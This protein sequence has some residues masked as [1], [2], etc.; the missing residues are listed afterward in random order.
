MD[1]FIGRNPGVPQRASEPRSGSATVAPPVGSPYMHIG[2]PL[3]DQT[4]TQVPAEEVGQTAGFALDRL[5]GSRS[6]IEPGHSELVTP[7][8]PRP[9][10]HSAGDHR[11]GL[12]GH[13]VSSGQRSDVGILGARTDHP[14]IV[15][16]K[17]PHRLRRQRRLKGV[18]VPTHDMRCSAFDV[19]RDQPVAELG[20]PCFE[21]START[22][23]VTEPV[24]KVIERRGP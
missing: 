14:L 5:V 21:P 4:Q 22:Q 23:A 9:A 20:E 6:L 24:V 18:D 3:R 7:A 10:E 13:E 17:E 16:G 12:A 1:A 19:D 2:D 11:V 15:P 8:R